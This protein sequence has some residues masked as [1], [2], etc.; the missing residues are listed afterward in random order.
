MA[1][2][3]WPSG[4]ASFAAFRFA[5]GLGEAGNWPGATKAVSEWFPRRET[6]WAVALF[7]SGSSIGGA[8]ARLIIVLTIYH[9]FERLA[10][11][12][13][14]H[15][16]ARV[17]LARRF[18]ARCTAVRRASPANHRLRNATTSSS[19]RAGTSQRS[20]TA[21]RRRCRH[22]PYRDPR[23]RLPQT[24]GYILSKTLHRPGVV[25]HHR[26]VRRSTSCAKGSS[27]RRAW[28]A[29]WVPFLAADLGNFF[30]GGFSSCLIARGWQRGRRPQVHRR[31]RRARH[32]AAGTGGLDVVASPRW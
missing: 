2:A 21:P 10:A 28:S 14:P 3:R 27:S 16:R 12:V 9:A 5:L 20:P 11:G 13:H 25:L 1:D 30:G 32:D 29:F 4:L 17:R 15:R 24:W 26:L 8:I 18:P 6:G 7:D 23:C 31:P 19:G 22:C